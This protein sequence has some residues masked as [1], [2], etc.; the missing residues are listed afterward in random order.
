MV[1]VVFASH[2]RA[3]SKRRHSA[4][5]LSSSRTTSAVSTASVEAPRSETETC[6]FFIAIESLMPSPT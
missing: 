1:A 4:F 5:R 2:S 6:D 3:M